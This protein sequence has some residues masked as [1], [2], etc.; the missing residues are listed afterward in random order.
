[1]YEIEGLGMREVCEVAGCP[2]QTGYSR[3]HAARQII[4]AAFAEGPAGGKP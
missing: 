3:L 4:E 2:L 1:L